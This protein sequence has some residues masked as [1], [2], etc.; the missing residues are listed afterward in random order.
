[1]KVKKKTD[2]PEP[3]TG[4]RAPGA[5]ARLA[6]R[7]LEAAREPLRDA[8][9]PR[10]WDRVW[11]SR[12]LRAAWAATTLVLAL[13]HV[14]LSVAPGGG[15]SSPAVAERDRADELREV[16]ELPTVEISPRAERIAMGA[17]LPPTTAPADDEPNDVVTK[18]EV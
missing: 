10:V 15:R 14:A 8:D 16:L 4:L 17:A 12:A 13:A 18:E 7:V 11:D 9:L 6:A 1:M 3:L 2:L 5:P